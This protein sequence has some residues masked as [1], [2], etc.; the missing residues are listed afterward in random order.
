LM[1]LVSRRSI[2]NVTRRIGQRNQKSQQ[3][4]R[5]IMIIQGPS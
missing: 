4:F 3:E 2:A 5:I 1:P